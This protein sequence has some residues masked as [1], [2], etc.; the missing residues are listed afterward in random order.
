MLIKNIWN[1]DLCVRGGILVSTT[2]IYSQILIKHFFYL[3]LHSTFTLS[4]PHIYY[5]YFSLLPSLYLISILLF[6]ELSIK[7]KSG[8]LTGIMKNKSLRGRMSVFMLV[9]TKRSRYH[10]SP[11]LP[12]WGSKA[13][14]SPKRNYLRSQ[15]HI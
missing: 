7:G 15:S 13:I 3:Y 14:H 4:L 2:L 12:L 1:E 5:I 6:R 10:C 9:F 11:F 8:L